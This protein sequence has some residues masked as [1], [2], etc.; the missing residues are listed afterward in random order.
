MAYKR[1]L[2]YL[3]ISGGN[4]AQDLWVILPL[5][6]GVVFAIVGGDE[7]TV[8]IVVDSDDDGCCGLFVI[9]VQLTTQGKQG[10]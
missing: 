10:E 6:T 9:W 4:C 7:D 2:T 3:M 8:V 5:Y 1:E